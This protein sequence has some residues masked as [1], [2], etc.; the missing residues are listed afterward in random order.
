MLRDVVNNDVVV[1]SCL[2]SQE[3]LDCYFSI[4]LLARYTVVGIYMAGFP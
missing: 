4:V 3:S 2:S 1:A